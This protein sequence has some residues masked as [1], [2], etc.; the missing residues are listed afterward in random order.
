M[1]AVPTI[2]LMMQ[3]LSAVSNVLLQALAA[4]HILLASFGKVHTHTHPALQAGLGTARDVK[5][6]RNTAA[7]CSVAFG[8]QRAGTKAHDLP[9][10]GSSCHS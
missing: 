10:L 2:Q 1:G 5:I 4:V 7:R 8:A 6:L 3:C 9:A